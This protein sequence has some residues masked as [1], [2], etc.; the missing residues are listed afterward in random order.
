MTMK[1][2]QSLHQ[3]NML[4]DEID[5][6]L[7]DYALFKSTTGQGCYH[8]DYCDNEAAPFDDWLS[9]VI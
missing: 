4:S 6:I 3:L 8:A 1:N 2:G 7:A 9:I 5:Q